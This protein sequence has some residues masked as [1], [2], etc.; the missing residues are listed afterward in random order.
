[1]DAS[2]WYFHALHRYLDYTKDYDFV[3]GLWGTLEE[4]IS[5]Y[6]DGISFGIRMGLDLM[7]RNIQ[8]WQGAPGLGM[9]NSGIKKSDAC[10]M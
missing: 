1:M 9:P 5:S 3:K 4:I 10:M 6:R 7:N 8:G 2:L